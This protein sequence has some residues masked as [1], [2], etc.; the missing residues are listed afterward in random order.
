MTAALA[1]QPPKCEHTQ[2]RR[3]SWAGWPE[4]RWQPATDGLAKPPVAACQG[5]DLRPRRRSRILV[6]PGHCTIMMRRGPV[7][8]KRPLSGKPIPAPSDNIKLGRAL[9]AMFVNSAVF[10]PFVGSYHRDCLKHL[11]VSDLGQA[12]RAAAGPVKCDQQLSDCRVQLRMFC[13][14]LRTATLPRTDWTRQA[15][16]GTVT[17]GSNPAT[18]HS[19]PP[20]SQH[21]G[22]ASTRIPSLHSIQQSRYSD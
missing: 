11:R 12:H 19:Q 13:L 8:Q 4:P 3:R 5:A 1:R 17:G 10:L 15:L 22:T 2:T 14:N 18:Q 7:W 6:A 20:V 16:Q 21:R 9:K